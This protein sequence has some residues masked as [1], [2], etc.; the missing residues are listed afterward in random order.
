MATGTILL[1]LLGAVPDATNP[2]E[3][4]FTTNG[5]PRY[6]FDTNTDEKIVWTFRVPE[7]Y[8]SAPILKVIFS[9]GITTGNF[10]YDTEVNRVLPGTTN[11]LTDTWQ[12]VSTVAGTPVP[13]PTANVAKLLSHTMGNLGSLA[14][15]DFMGL[16]FTRDTGTSG[17]ANADVAVWAVSLEYTT[18]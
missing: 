15:N 18:T 4:I 14:A 13:T 16:R 12:A 7:N 10:A 6:S 17:D 2:P 11:I 5:R 8:A 3:L 9:C 1:P